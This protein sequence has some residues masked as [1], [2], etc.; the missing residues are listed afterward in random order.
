M[1]GIAVDSPVPLRLAGHA[2]KNYYKTVFIYLDFNSLK[3]IFEIK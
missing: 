2:P 1:A 3:C